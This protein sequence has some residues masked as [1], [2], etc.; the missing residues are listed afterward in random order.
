MMTMRKRGPLYQSS[1]TLRDR[2][3]ATVSSPL[4]SPQSPFL[5]ARALEYWRQV[6]LQKP[7]LSNLSALLKRAK[8]F[9]SKNYANPNLTWLQQPPNKPRDTGDSKY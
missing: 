3:I 5:L 6:E 2:A 8:P 7:R 4:V 1:I 9:S